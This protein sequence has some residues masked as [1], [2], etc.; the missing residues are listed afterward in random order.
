VDLQALKDFNLDCITSMDEFYSKKNL[1][2]LFVQLIADQSGKMTTD[3]QIKIRD[4]I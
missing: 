1:E 3:I 2:M 4:L